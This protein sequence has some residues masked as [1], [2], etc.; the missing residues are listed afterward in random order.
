VTHAYTVPGAGRSLYADF[1]EEAAEVLGGE[2]TSDAASAFR[3]SGELG[4]RLA[5]I[6]SGASDDLTRYAELADLRSAQL[7][8]QP[9]AE[10]MATFHAEQRD[11]VA[12]CDLTPIETAD[13]FGRLGEVLAEIIEIEQPA[14]ERLRDD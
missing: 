2:R 8:G 11:L 5:A 4:S 7:D 6:A 10:Q 1:L 3:R 14:L 9:V 13:V 12:N